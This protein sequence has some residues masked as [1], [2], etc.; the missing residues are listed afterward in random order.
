M[1]NYSDK[2]QFFYTL[3]YGNSDNLKWYPIKILQNFKKITKFFLNFEILQIFCKYFTIILQLSNTK[4][5]KI[6][7][8]HI[9]IL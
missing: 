1:I 2:K 9:K 5:E 3:N 7:K 6:K 4:C 8:L